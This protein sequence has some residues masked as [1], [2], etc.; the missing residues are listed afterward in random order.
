MTIQNYDIIYSNL[1][2]NN[3]KQIEKKLHIPMD[4]AFNLN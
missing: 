3:L 4:R 2:N 1:N